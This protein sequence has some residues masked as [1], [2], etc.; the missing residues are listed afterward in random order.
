MDTKRLKTFAAEAR[1][2][3]MLGVGQRLEALGFAPN[4]SVT[5][6]P[7]LL[8]GGAIFMGNVVSQDF[9]D[10]WQSL[11][12]AISQTSVADVA[13]EASYTWFNRLM[14]I[15]IM[16][17]NHL[18]SPVLEYEEEGSLIPLLVADARRGLLSA[19]LQAVLTQAEKEQV[20]E[21]LNNETKVADLFSLLIVAYCHSNPVIN[22]CFGNM[23][24]YTELLLPNGILSAGGFVNMLN[25]SP[26]ITEEDFRSPELIGWLYEF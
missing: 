19:P 24:D 3:L 16:V 15:R 14:A 9:Y 25:N 21:L 1:K 8:E 18:T 20:E 2:V 6:E 23:T 10:K 22:R 12:K 17:K 4:G 13:E 5:T 26:F 11:R 7:Q